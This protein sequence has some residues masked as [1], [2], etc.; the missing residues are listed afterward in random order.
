MKTAILTMSY[1]SIKN[2]ADDIA[3]VLRENGERVQVFTTQTIVNDY[4][5]LVIFIPF[6]PAEL[7]P[8]LMTYHYFKG[9]KH[10]Y[11]TA[12]GIPR[13][14]A[15]NPYLLKEITF[16]P[17]SQFS[18]QNLMTVDI[19]VDVPVFHGVNLDLVERAEKIVPTLRE[20]L[21]R[22][23]PNAL[24]I[25]V[26]T[27]TTKRKNI[28]LFVETANVLNQQYPD[29]A[30]KVHF[31]VISHEDFKKLTVPAN[32]HFVSKFGTQSHENVLAFIGA[33]DLMF[34]PSGCEGFGLVLLEAMAMGTPTIHQAIAPFIEFTSWQ[35]NFMI[36]SVSVEEYYDKD[37]MQTWKISR[38]N[39]HDAILA[40]A[41]A[42]DAGDLQERREKLKEIAKKYDIRLLYQR[43][44]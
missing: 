16:I 37:H 19:N 3:T 28:D 34:I 18:A 8:Y 31:F 40:I 39:P 1:S 32:V 14:T 23:F 22:D 20:K 12:D 24:K 44:L 5:K 17:N 9:P 2:V 25:G 6:L 33:M 38:F 13:T 27:G 15:I 41:K 10:F 36:P 7:N 35:Y 26:V 11:I 4:D 29:L 30:K 21:D 43:F 42:I